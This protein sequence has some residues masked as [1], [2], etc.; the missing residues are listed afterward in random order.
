VL[1]ALRLRPRGSALATW[2]F[3]AR[4]AWASWGRVGAPA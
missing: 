1:A 4:F 3:G 2:G